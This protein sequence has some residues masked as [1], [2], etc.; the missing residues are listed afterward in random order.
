MRQC[1]AMTAEVR[2]QWGQNI[3]DGRSILGLR[4]E[5]L[6]GAIRVRQ[7]TVSKWERGLMAP[8]DRMKVRLATVLH[9]DVR[10][11]FPLTRGMVN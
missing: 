1:Q 10:Q 9:Q 8:T 2:R 6:A 3:R 4:Q 7:S 5:D 11:L